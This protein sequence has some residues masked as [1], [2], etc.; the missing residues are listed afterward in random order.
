VEG[1][2]PD[3]GLSRLEERRRRGAER[4][5]GRTDRAGVTGDRD[6]GWRLWLEGIVPDLNLPLDQFG[7]E[8]AVRDGAVRQLHPALIEI[9][10]EPLPA[11]GFFVGLLLPVLRVRERPPE[12]RRQRL[13]LLPLRLE[14]R[15]GK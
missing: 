11:L 5:V 12:V 4:R 9:L 3:L 15:I 6:R 1:G 8:E 14:C 7:G 10:D 13:P 2:D